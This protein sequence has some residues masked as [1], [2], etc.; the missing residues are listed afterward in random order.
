MADEDSTFFATLYGEEMEL[1]ITEPDEDF[2][3][4]TCHV[5]IKK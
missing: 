1:G 3:V 5:M 4:A 2:R